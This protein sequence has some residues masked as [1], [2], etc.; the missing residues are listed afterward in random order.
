MRNPN[1]TNAMDYAGALTRLQSSG[2]GGGEPMSR[3]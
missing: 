1:C 3:E 2:F